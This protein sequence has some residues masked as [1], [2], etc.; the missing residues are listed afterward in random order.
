MCAHAKTLAIRWLLL[1]LMVGWVLSGAAQ[2]A[3]KTAIKSN[4]IIAI[5]H[6][7]DIE[8]FK[9]FLVPLRKVYS[10]DIVLFTLPKLKPDIHHLCK[11]MGVTTARMTTRYSG[12][13]ILDRFF[14]YSTVCS[15]YDR[16]IA[17]DFRDVFFQSDPFAGLGEAANYELVISQEHRK[18]IGTSYYN[19]KWI[20][21]CWGVTTL[22]NIGHNL[23]ICSGVLMGT[24]KGFRVLA[25]SFKY[26]ID[27]TRGKNCYMTGIDQGFLNFLYYKNKIPTRI[28][29]QPA[30]TGFVNTLGQ[31]PKASL[32]YV[33]ESGEVYNQNK[34]PS[35]MIHQYDRFPDVIAMVKKRVSLILS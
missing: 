30:G 4:V 24:P 8:T 15:D 17:T 13:M 22:R 12:S 3:R 9:R 20:L 21:N 10:G 18:T 2:P 31:Y 26:E 25:E 16:C 28:L 1:G 29:A 33:T 23:I 35:P 14:A 11:K 6:G 27:A 5:A 34:F 7:Y 19:S 32:Q